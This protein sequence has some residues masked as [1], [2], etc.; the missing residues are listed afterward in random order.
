VNHVKPKA[1]LE[2]F[3]RE[4]A[5]IMATRAPLTQRATKMAV[6]AHLADHTSRDMTAANNAAAA[7]F[8]SDDY[9][10]G[11]SSFMEKRAPIFTGR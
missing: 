10:E 3:V 8:A 9:A 4:Q 6:A 11:V 1:E 2:A 5:S 7:C